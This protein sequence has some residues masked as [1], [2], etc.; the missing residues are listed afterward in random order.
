MVLMI[1]SCNSKGNN[2]ET[3]DTTTVN[4]STSNMPEGGPNHGLGDTNSYNR[5]NDTVAHDTT[6]NE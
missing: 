5:M 1:V 2:T 3:S 4:T 6:R